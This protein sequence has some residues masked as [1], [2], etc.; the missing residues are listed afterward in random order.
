VAIYPVHAE[1]ESSL[2]L[3]GKE[4]I[5]YDL[6]HVCRRRREDPQQRS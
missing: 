4:N 3:M 6:I 2:H 5:S 1:S